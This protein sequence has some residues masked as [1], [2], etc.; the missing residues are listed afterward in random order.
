MACFDEGELCMNVKTLR[1]IHACV[2]S[3]RSSLIIGGFH[4]FQGI[5]VENE[6]LK[7][8]VT[9]G[10]EE[11]DN[12]LMMSLMNQINNN[13]LNDNDV[14]GTFGSKSAAFEELCM[15]ECGTRSCP[16]DTMHAVFVFHPNTMS[17]EKDGIAP[18]MMSV[19]TLHFKQ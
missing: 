19:I 6:I 4:R 5:E 2:P 7:R 15:P 14:R 12:A 18:Q 8:G 11:E 10:H 13:A 1:P 16:S 17:Y 3:I 9:A